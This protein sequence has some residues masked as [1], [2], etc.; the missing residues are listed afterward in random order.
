[1]SSLT[2]F[3]EIIEKVLE[4][5]GGYVYD[6]DDPGG[7]TNFGI[8]KKA[9]PTTDIKNLT[10]D[11][12]KTIYHQDYWRPNKC[13]SLSS[14][15]RHLYF[16]SCINQGA[17]KAVKILQ[18]AVNSKADTVLKVDGKL[19]PKT[20]AATQNLELDRAKAYRIKA[21]VHIISFNPR[22]NKYFY[23]WYKRVL[24]I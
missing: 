19:G 3:E 10:K 9:Y 24:A 8:S 22:L 18:N 6:S 17:V 21:Y 14:H 1:M 15:L 20:L 2:T 4:D 11:Q 7:E 5:E 12:A 16:D 23:G 13:D